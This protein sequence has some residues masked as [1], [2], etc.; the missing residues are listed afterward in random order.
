MLWMS[1]VRAAC[2]LPSGGVHVKRMRERGKHKD[3]GGAP[4]ATFIYRATLITSVES[5]DILIISKYDSLVLSATVFLVSC[6][7]KLSF[8]TTLGRLSK[9]TFKV[10]ITLLT[11]ILL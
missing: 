10:H 1:S 2:R 11:W 5:T 8:D 4:V 6:L 3:R 9:M 7:N